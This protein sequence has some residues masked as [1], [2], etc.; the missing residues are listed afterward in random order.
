MKH[1]LH[2]FCAFGLLLTVTG[3]EK[4]MPTSPEVTT[5]PEAVT[6]SDAVLSFDSL[7]DLKA[8]ARE[9][10][11]MSDEGR[12][13]WYAEQCPDFVSQNEAM[14][15]VVDELNEQPDMAALRACQTK[16]DGLFL[17][18]PNEAEMDVSPYIPHDKP[19]YD[20]ICNAYGNV[21]IAG[22]I[23]NCNEYTQ[24]EETSFARGVKAWRAA[25]RARE[26]IPNRFF[27]EGRKYRMWME[28][29]WDGTSNVIEIKYDAQQ[30]SWF[31]WNKYRTKY[32]VSRDLVTVKLNIAN[33]ESFYRDVWNANGAGVW[34]REMSGTVYERA[35]YI[36][37]ITKEVSIG[38][39]VRSN[40][41]S[42]ADQG[43]LKISYNQPSHAR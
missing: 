34:T 8:T 25:T 24:Y 40:E 13:A 41:M 33:M 38:F 22:E 16:Y 1:W 37:D 26:E 32:L 28:S 43:I 21:Q 39:H 15:M 3:C 20:L 7:D 23:I 36:A 14:W 4:E 17:F 18:N 9:L 10:G 12:R 30:K 19:G 27:I 29:F 11:T 31:G 2:Y 6:F 35:L 42:E 5:A